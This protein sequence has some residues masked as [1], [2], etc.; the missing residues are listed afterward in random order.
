MSVRTIYGVCREHDHI[1]VMGKAEIEG[2]HVKLDFME[3]ALERIGTVIRS[4]LFIGSRL[5]S[6]PGD[7]LQT[8]AGPE[9]HQTSIWANPRGKRVNQ[10]IQVWRGG[11]V[12]DD[13]VVLIPTV[14]LEKIAGFEP[15][16]DGFLRRLT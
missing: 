13:L 5:Q 10:R 11:P 16:Q 8:V 12:S 2:N 9:L 15:K 14:G 1:G 6:W 4:F 7:L 3:D